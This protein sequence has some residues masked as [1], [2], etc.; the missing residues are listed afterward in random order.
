MKGWNKRIL[1]HSYLILHK[2][3]NT[4]FIISKSEHYKRAADAGLGPGADWAKRW[5]PGKRRSWVGEKHIRAA[6]AC[7]HRLPKYVRNDR[8]V[9]IIIIDRQAV[10]G[11]FNLKLSTLKIQVILKQTTKKT[12]GNH[13]FKPTNLP[14]TLFPQGGTGRFFPVQ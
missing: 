3:F 7:S 13:S 5:S 2:I 9:K 10:F 4:G 1:V 6:C 8:D 14:A 12:L 11:K